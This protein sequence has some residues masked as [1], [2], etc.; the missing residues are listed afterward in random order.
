M[1][2]MDISESVSSGHGGGIYLKSVLNV[3][4]GSNSKFYNNSVEQN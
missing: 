3:K 4:L 1:K 2:E